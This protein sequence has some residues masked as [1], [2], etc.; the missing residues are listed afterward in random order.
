MMISLRLATTTGE[1]MKKFLAAAVLSAFALPAFAVG[2]TIPAV[3]PRDMVHD[4]ARG[5]VYVSTPTEVLRFQ[6]STGT[7]LSPITLSSQYLAG[8]DIS[9]DNR[10]L[11]VADE[12]YDPA[13]SCLYIVDLDAL[14]HQRPCGPRADDGEGGTESVVYGADGSIYANTSIFNSPSWP[15]RRFEPVSGQWQQISTTASGSQLSASGDAQTIGFVDYSY[16]AG[17]IWGFVDVPTGGVVRRAFPESRFATDLDIDRLGGQFAVRGDGEGFY[18]FD[19]AYAPVGLIPDTSAMDFGYHPVERVGYRIPYGSYVLQIHDMNTLQQTGSID[20]EGNPNFGGMSKVKLSRDGSLIMTM[21][22]E[23]VR[24]YEQY[25][26][27]QAIAINAT[28]NVGQAKAITLAGSVGNGGTLVY[29]AAGAPL[30]GSVTINSLGAAV[31]TPMPGFVGSDSFSYRVQYG[32]AE[33]TAT[34]WMTVV[35][36]NRAP[37]AV[38][39]NAATRNTAILIPVLANDSDPDG[40]VLSI[41]SVTA[42]TAGAAVIQGTRVQFTP[43]KKWPAAPVTFNYTISDG[44][45]KSATAKVTVTRN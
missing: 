7:F 34:V 10:F 45:G 33:R 19:E 35:D 5:L 38:N 40:D 32:R 30:H 43:P 42:P 9:P 13:G 21:T 23:D 37:V 29:S 17:G 25:A 1:N 28:T 44:R 27:L 26:P 8:I 39:D 18:V 2:T 15:L 6:L 36:P 20:F 11:V 14:T 16:P 12:T 22:F 3:Q 24:V 41:A 31:Y 4:D